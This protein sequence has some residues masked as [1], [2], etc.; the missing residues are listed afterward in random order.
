MFSTGYLETNLVLTNQIDLKRK[1]HQDIIS[2]VLTLKCFSF[3][4]SN[5]TSLNDSLKMQTHGKYFYY[6]YIIWQQNV[7]S[8]FHLT[9]IC[10]GFVATF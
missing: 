9:V 5:S 3:N 8:W 6:Y 1:Y 4:F 2:D 10:F 7:Q